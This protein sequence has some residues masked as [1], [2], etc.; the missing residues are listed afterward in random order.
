[1]AAP[2][3]SAHSTAVKQPACC[4][5]IAKARACASQGS[6]NKGSF[7]A[8]RIGCSAA[9]AQALSGWLKVALPQVEMDTVARIGMLAPQFP[10]REAHG[11]EM[12]RHIALAVRA[13][14]RQ[15][16]SAVMADDAAGLA[17]GIARQTRVSGGL[18]IA[19]PHALTD[20]EPRL[21]VQIPS[22]LGTIVEEAPDRLRAHRII[23]F[24]RLGHAGFQ[25]RLLGDVDP[26]LV[27]GLRQI[28]IRPQRLAQ[29]AEPVD[30][31]TGGEGHDLQ[32]TAGPALPCL[33]KRRL[34]AFGVDCAEPVHAAQVVN[35]VHFAETLPTPIM[36]SRVTS[37]ASCSSLIP[38][39]PA[40]RSGSTR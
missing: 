7:S 9:S 27:V 11:V 16:V 5:A 10:R 37:A 40:G 13:G 25:Q 8:R 4:K 1:M 22:A 23:A 3:A 24:R 6:A 35:R 12:L 2:R 20:G 14:I 17:A 32:E 31:E 29:I 26:L 38:S 15:H 39:V 36:E 28:E 19:R 21:A 18:H 30:G 34:V 33:M